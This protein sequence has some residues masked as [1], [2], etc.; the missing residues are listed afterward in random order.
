MLNKIEVAGRPNGISIK[1][2]IGAEVKQYFIPVTRL[3]SPSP[4]D[5]TPVDTR[6]GWA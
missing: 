1:H 6:S 2:P 4:G 3:T 5:P